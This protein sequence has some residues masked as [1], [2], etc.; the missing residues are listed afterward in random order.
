MSRLQKA[1][2]RAWP[3]PRVARALA[4]LPHVAPA[5][6]L[7]GRLEAEGRERLAGL[8]AYLQALMASDELRT[9]EQLVYFSRPTSSPRA[10][11]GGMQL[12]GGTRLRRRPDD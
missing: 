8:D 7:D 3:V 11:V 4:R 10:A 12:S 2:G 9:S 5:R 6:G 1:L